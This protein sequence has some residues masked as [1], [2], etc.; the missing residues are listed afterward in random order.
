MWSTLYATDLFA[1]AGQNRWAHWDLPELV[2]RFPDDLELLDYQRGTIID[3]LNLFPMGESELRHEGLGNVE[4]AFS[5][6]ADV[7]PSNIFDFHHHGNWVKLINLL[8]SL[9]SRKDY[10]SHYP[11]NNVRDEN[12]WRMVR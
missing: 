9:Q 3:Q 8:D 5:I 6:P 4:P 11:Y 10:I 2:R 1:G 7:Y 12:T